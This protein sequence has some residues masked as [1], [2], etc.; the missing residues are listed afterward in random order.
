MKGA[1]EK[2]VGVRD[3]V[4][5][6]EEIAG[7][8]PRYRIGGTGKDGTCDCIGLVIGAIRRAGGTWSG[9]RGTNYTARNEMVSLSSIACNSEL[10]VGEVVFKAR[11]PGEKGYDADTIRRNYASS[12]DKRDYYHI[13]VVMSVY[14]LR[15]RHMTTPAAKMDTKL[16]A[17]SHHGWCSLV[18]KEQWNHADGETGVSI[19]RLHD[20]L[21]VIEKQLD[22]IYDMT[23]GR[24]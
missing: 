12:P 15:I 20:C 7:E 4:A 14:P 2:L 16:G 17:W 8:E 6:V 19:D 5:K 22:E 10:K 13:W 1:W 18:E 24:G 9:L 23:G 3:F 11:D 21:A